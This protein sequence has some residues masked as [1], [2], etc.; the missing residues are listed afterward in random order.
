MDWL[1]TVAQC[2]FFGLLLFTVFRCFMRLS[3]LDARFF[4]IE[5][6]IDA[7]LDDSQIDF[8]AMFRERMAAVLSKGGKRAAVTH[9]FLSTGW[10]MRNAVDYVDELAAEIEAEKDGDGASETNS[11][12]SIA[13]MD[14]DEFH[15]LVDQAFQRPVG[16]PRRRKRR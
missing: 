12:H 2:C 13:G 11:P 4:F 3:Y 8:P 16:R 9:C 15:D 1:W 5:S 7:L 6:K 14:V 10:D